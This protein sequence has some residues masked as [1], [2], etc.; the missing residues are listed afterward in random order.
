MPKLIINSG[1]RLDG[2]ISIQGAKN[3]LLPILAASL[4]GQ[5]KSVIHNCPNLRDTVSAMEILKTL[6]CKVTQEEHTITVDPQGMSN[7]EIPDSLMRQMRSSIMFLGAILGK[8]GKAKIS[9]PGGCELGPRPIDLHLSALEKMGASF[10]DEFGFLNCSSEKGLKGAQIS[11]SIPS[12]GATENIMLAAATAKGITTIINAAREP[13]ICDL[14]DFMNK[15][16]AKIQGAGTN[17]IVVNGVKSLNGAEHSVIPDRIATST[18]LICVA[19]TGGKAKLLNSR[20]SHL[21]AVLS[22]LTDAGCNL[23]FTDN[24]INLI[25]S[26]VP[27]PL[28][29]IR[30]MPYP[31]FPTDAQA[32]LMS[33][34]TTAS[35]TSILVETIFDNRYKHAEELIRMGA[36]IKIEGRVALIEGV[37]KLTG[38]TVEATDLRGGAALVIAGLM[39][40]GSTEIDKIH[41]IERGYDRIDNFL[42]SLGADIKRIEN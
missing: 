1:R 6:G 14:Q 5:N 28:K 32:L 24:E 41:H 33:Y 4:L 31:G 38:T 39:A 21:M 11:L 30:T 19:A 27:K 10:I 36:S 26:P 18:Y 23:S 9:V 7:F 16:G 22:A 15:M 37:K 34:L 35:G 42:A 40:D 8:M 12:V 20:P 13:E 25:K 3:S 29:N 17:I 2:T